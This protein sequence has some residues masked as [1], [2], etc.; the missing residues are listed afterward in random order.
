LYLSDTGGQGVVVSSSDLNVSGGD[1]NLGVSDTSATGAL[2]FKGGFG[3]SIRA[4]N[5]VAGND[6][7]A[8]KNT[9]GSAYGSL[10]AEN[11]FPGGQGSAYLTHDGNF[12]FNDGVYIAGALTATGTVTGQGLVKALGTIE[13]DTPTTTTLTT[14][15]ARWTLIAGTNYRLDRITSSGRYKTNIVDAGAEV[16]TASRRI[17]PRHYESIIEHEAGETRLGFIAEEV[18]EA[19]LSHGVGLNAEGLPDTLDP[20]ALLAA[21]FV[22]IADLEARLEDLEGIVNG[23]GHR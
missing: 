3:G 4:F 10:V 8:I 18:M 21:A 20:I 9:S 14:N 1:I 6:S 7:I 23:S 19:G 22:R 17:R 11:F 16:L 5:A 15:G 13:N 12:S 2:I